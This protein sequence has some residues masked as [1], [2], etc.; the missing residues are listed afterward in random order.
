MGS[1]DSKLLTIVENQD[2][3]IID[4]ETRPDQLNFLETHPLSRISDDLGKYLGIGTDSISL[5][6]FLSRAAAR[7]GQPFNLA[8]FSENPGTEHLIADRLNNILSETV[9][10][11]ETIKQFRDLAEKRFENTELIIVRSKHE[12]LVRFACETACRDISTISAPCVWLITDERCS[13]AL[14]GPTLSLM[15]SQTDRSFTGFGHHFSTVTHG[16][17]EEPFNQLRALLLQLG[18]R[19]LPTC[20]FI[21]SVRSE[22]KPDEMLIVNRLLNTIASLRIGLLHAEGKFLPS[23]ETMVSIDDYRVTRELLNRLPVP[24]QHSNLSPYAAETGEIL[25]YETFCDPKY[26]QTV[27]D[28]SE[29][30]N[31]A[32]TRNFAKDVTGFSYNTVKDHLAKLEGEGVLKSLVVTTIRKGSL[33]RRQG[34]Q[35]YY[36]FTNSRSPP[37]GAN[38]PFTRLPTPEEIAVDYSLPLQSQGK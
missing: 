3:A 18:T 32:F 8:I 31:K 33:V 13:V 14:V 21:K 37:F 35:I 10:F 20:R 34:L 12:R 19:V 38:S 1:T 7:L 27:P 25:Y 17:K 4:E 30:G 16:I 28:N 22:L 24:A 15:A 36:T 11:A 23:S 29:F 9:K 2:Q 26:Q 6:M 5:M